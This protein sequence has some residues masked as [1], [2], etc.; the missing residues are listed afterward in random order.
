MSN[1]ENIKIFIVLDSGIPQIQDA[2]IDTDS[3]CFTITRGLLRRL[4]LPDEAKEVVNDDQH[5]P[6]HQGV[7]HRSKVQLEVRSQFMLDFITKYFCVV[8]SETDAIVQPEYLSPN[9]VLPAQEAVLIIANA[10]NSSSR[11]ESC[12]KEKKSN[13]C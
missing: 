9:D 3:T 4:S 6:V 11:G 5:P 1:P 7:I 13:T 12:L 2:V 8:E 10:R